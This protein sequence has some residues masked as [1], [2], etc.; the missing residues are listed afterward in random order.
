MNRKLNQ[1]FRGHAE[2]C[3]YGFT[4]NLPDQL[5]ASWS[6]QQSLDAH[7]EELQKQGSII[8]E[9][10]LWEDKLSG[11]FTTDYLVE[12]TASASPLWWSLIIIGVIGLLG[13]L[14]TAWAIHEV[15]DIA[16]YSPGLAAGLTLTLALGI[17]AALV[18]GAMLMRRRD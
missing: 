8:L 1:D 6:A 3:Q 2:M 18:A 17:T 16:E 15:K 13:I 5:S 4:V 14:A 10:K 9:Y 12:V 7:I 11:T